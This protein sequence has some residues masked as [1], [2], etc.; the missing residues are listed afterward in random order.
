MAGSST[1][2]GKTLEG[3]KLDS[4]DLWGHSLTVAFGSRL[5]ASKKKPDMENDAFAAG[6]IHDA[7]KLVLDAY[8][9]ERRDLFEEFVLNGEQT[10]LNAEKE[11]LGFDHSEIA[12]EVCKTWKI[13]KSL[14][15]AIRYHHH[16]SR[17]HGDEL[18]NIIHVA[19]SLALMSGIGAGVDGML[20]KT[21]SKAIELLDLDEEALTEIIT[22]TA[23]TVEKIRES[24]H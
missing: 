19:D 7:G 1:L 2:L 23:E 24:L 8:I 14:N 21:D 16:P 5:I 6:L 13:P 15:N 9:Y 11:I 12:A 22:Q 20:Y 18:T 4:G 10:F 3:Y 17:A